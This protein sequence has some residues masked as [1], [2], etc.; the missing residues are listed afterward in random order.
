MLAI[1][2]E[3]HLYCVAVLDAAD[4]RV[5]ELYQGELVE[6]V[7]DEGGAVEHVQAETELAEHL[8][9]ALLRFPL[10]AQPS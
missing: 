3:L 9:A 10:P 5:W 1:L 7:I 8:V 2:D 6:A 4:A